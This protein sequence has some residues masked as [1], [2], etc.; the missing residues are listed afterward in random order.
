MNKKKLKE[1]NTQSLVFLRGDDAPFLD[2]D[3]NPDDYI[4]E[5]KGLAQIL[6]KRGLWVD[7]IM[8]KGLT[9]SIKHHIEVENATMWQK[10]NLVNIKHFDGNGNTWH[11]VYR[12]T[13]VPPEHT[14]VKEDDE[15]EVEALALKKYSGKKV[16]KPTSNKSMV[17]SSLL[18]FIPPE[19][20][21][22]HTERRLARQARVQSVI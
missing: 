10:Y 19:L 15:I 7:G 16:Y 6:Y 2:P 11:G 4:G 8:R 5:P 21:V 22:L 3:A 20:T 17:Q 9:R 1:G 18:S 13:H 12:I 14:N